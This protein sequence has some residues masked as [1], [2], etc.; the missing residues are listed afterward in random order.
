MLHS[1]FWR[2][3]G[4][5][6]QLRLTRIFFCHRLTTV[7]QV[8][9]RLWRATSGFLKC[10]IF[11]KCKLSHG[12]TSER[13][14][15]IAVVAVKIISFRT[16]SGDSAM[17]E[18]ICQR[19]YMVLQYEINIRSKASG[20]WLLLNCRNSKKATTYFSRACSQRSRTCHQVFSRST[21][22]FW[23]SYLMSC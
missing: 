10:K 21:D 13:W 1:P 18:N 20:I 15:N 8:L 22:V 9:P 2:R 12:W 4:I 6:R 16:V 7:V 23:S 14:P 11:M 19:K 5:S 17:N 3:T